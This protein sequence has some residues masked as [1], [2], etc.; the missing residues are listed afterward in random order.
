MTP[1]LATTPLAPR[2]RASDLSSLEQQHIIKKKLELHLKNL[3]PKSF[4]HESESLPGLVLRSSPSAKGQIETIPSSQK[5]QVDL[6]LMGD[7]IRLKDPHFKNA[8]QEK[9]ANMILSQLR[10]DR[11]EF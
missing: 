10:R 5:T 9:A 11:E 4:Q 2:Q 7:V 6:A 8:N 3:E 1:G